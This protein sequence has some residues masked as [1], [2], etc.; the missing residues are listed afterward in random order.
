MSAVDTSLFTPE[1]VFFDFE[2]ADREEFF[3]KLGEELKSRGYVKD[4]WHEA[5]TTREKNYPTG[6]ACEA[7]QVAIPHT[8]PEHLE[9]PYIAV[10]RPKSPVDFELMGGIGDTVHAELVIN[11]GLLAHANDQVAVLQALMMV[12]MDDAAVADVLAQTTPE[13]MVETMVKYCGREQ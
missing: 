6:L 11:L 2:A 13:G 7:V 9:K 4:T 10:I 12:F 8:D 5:I 1:L 3:A